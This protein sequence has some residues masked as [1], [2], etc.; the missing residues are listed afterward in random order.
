[1]SVEAEL[2]KLIQ[3]HTKDAPDVYETCMYVIH[4]DG[5]MMAAEGAQSN[6][7]THV[8]DVPPESLMIMD[9]YASGMVRNKFYHENYAA[10]S[11]AVARD[12]IRTK[13]MYTHARSGDAGNG[14][15][16]VVA[17]DLIAGRYDAL[18]TVIFCHGGY[19]A[20]YEF[21]VKFR[22]IVRTTQ[23]ESIMLRSVV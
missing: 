4:S 23:A 15:G 12:H 14:Q 21:E 8:N 13:T 7:S 1:M 5:V 22:A 11:I 20:C 9:R 18:G 6:M 19:D 17:R 16:M 3:E 10:I 2:I